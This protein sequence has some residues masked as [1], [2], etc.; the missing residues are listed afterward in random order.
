MEELETNS[1][2]T[3]HMWAIHGGG[4]LQKQRRLRERRIKKEEGGWAPNL[5]GAERIP[6]VGFDKE[7]I[8]LGLFRIHRVKYQFRSQFTVQI[9]FYSISSP[10]SV[11]LKSHPADHGTDE[12]NSM[13][14]HREERERRMGA[15]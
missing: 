14:E 13:E 5:W 11:S 12:G 6:A 3:P 1:N 15:I 10:H 4:T 2:Q 7:F 9:S 8:C